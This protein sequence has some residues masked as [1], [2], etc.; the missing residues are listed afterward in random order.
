MT[1]MAAESLVRA[2]G[3]AVGHVD[4]AVPGAAADEQARL[5]RGVLEEAEVPH[6]SV[7]HGQFDLLALQVRGLRVE[8]HELHRLVIASGR[9][10]VP[11]G[12]PGH[13]VDRPLVMPRPFEQHRRLVRGVLLSERGLTFTPTPV[14]CMEYVY[15]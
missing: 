10:E 14:I 4:L 5:V 12:R 7:V 11:G 9:H 8:P 3:G 15:L 1:A 6:G 13:A 2:A